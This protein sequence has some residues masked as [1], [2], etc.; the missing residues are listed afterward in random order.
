MDVSR[1][2]SPVV[3]FGDLLVKVRRLGRGDEPRSER[4]S[5]R[6]SALVGMMNSFRRFLR[7]SCS[8]KSKACSFV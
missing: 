4:F 8:L 2:E 3:T 6:R 5:L 1:D 7:G